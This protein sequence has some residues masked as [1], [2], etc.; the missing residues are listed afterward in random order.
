LR[1]GRGEEE[2]MLR[3]VER[4]VGTAHDLVAKSGKR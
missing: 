1:R 2:S 3:P 4:Q